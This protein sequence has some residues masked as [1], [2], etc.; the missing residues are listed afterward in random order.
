MII[1]RRFASRTRVNVLLRLL[2]VMRICKYLSTVAGAIMTCR[3]AG[4]S[5]LV[6]LETT[7][8]QR[9][10]PTLWV[11]ALIFGSVRHFES[12]SR[13]QSYISVD[14]ISTVAWVEWLCSS[15]A[16]VTS[17]DVHLN[18]I[19]ADH[20]S[21]MIAWLSLHRDAYMGKTAERWGDYHAWRGENRSRTSRKTGLSI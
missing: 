15:R 8:F 12:Q 21:R 3:C 5:L 20:Y 1:I 9:S 4:E 18:C 11:W 19:Y 17:A 14:A 6:Y 13:D 2:L 10:V 7:C 16:H